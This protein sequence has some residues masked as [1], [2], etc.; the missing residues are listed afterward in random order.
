MS[1]LKMLDGM[2]YYGEQPRKQGIIRGPAKF[3]HTESE[4]GAGLSKSW[5]IIN[6]PVCCLAHT[7]D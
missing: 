7:P 1:N 4:H 6:R 3:L 2:I 5:V